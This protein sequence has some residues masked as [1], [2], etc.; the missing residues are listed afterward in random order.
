MSD[1][2]PP[3]PEPPLPPQAPPA[4]V[5]PAYTPPPAYVPPQPPGAPGVPYGTPPPPKKKRTVVIIAVVVAVLLL[6]C[7]LSAGLGA[8]FMVRSDS[9]GDISFNDPTGLL[10]QD[11][12]RLE[13]WLAWDPEVE[14][15]MAPAPA[16]TEPAMV[17]AMGVLS[18][19]FTFSEAVWEQGYYEE[20]DNW[21]WAD[22]FYVRAYH[23]S[24]TDVSAALQFWIQS[25]QMV[26]E[27]VPFDADPED[28][29]ATLSDGRELLY[30]PQWFGPGFNVASADDEALWQQIGTDWPEA[31]VF[32][33]EAND[34]GTVSVQFTTWRAFA[35]PVQS[36]YVLATYGFGIG[37][38]WELSTWEYVYPDAEENTDAEPSTA[39]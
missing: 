20:A 7:C 34:D 24:S 39:I 9:T 36:P 15:M 30:S 37:D 5:T 11:D 10:Q 28:A 17:E 21:Y 3:Y 19:D 27:Q 12:P 4:G 22:A 1:Q 32:F 29:V 13:E 25:D 14:A 33:G 38:S 31:V 16:D 26:T 18:P 6:C 35:I 23:P 2:Q 8:L